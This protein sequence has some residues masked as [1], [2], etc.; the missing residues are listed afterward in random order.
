M[1]ITFL[2]IL[3]ALYLLGAWAFSLWPFNTPKVQAWETNHGMK[4][5]SMHY[6]APP[7]QA[8]SVGTATNAPPQ[9]PTPPTV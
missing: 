3:L 8:A 9:P 7:P 6:D 5:P 1:I 2:I 4:P